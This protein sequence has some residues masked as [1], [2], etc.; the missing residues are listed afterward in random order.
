MRGIVLI[1]DSDE[2]DADDTLNELV[3]EGL[4]E[5]IEKALSGQTI[6]LSKMWDGI[7]VE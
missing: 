1:T 2:L 3:L 6:P 5:G 4:R 7:D